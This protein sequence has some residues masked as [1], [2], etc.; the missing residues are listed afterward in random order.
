[1]N[2]R[3]SKFYF[4]R[5]AWYRWEINLQRFLNRNS[6]H[7]SPSIP[8]ADDV[9]LELSLLFTWPV[10]STLL[11]VV[12]NFSGLC[13]KDDSHSSASP[14]FSFICVCLLSQS[15]PTLCD[16][17]DCSPPGSSVCM[18][19]QARILEWV[20]SPPSGDLSN[21]GIKPTSSVSPALQ[22]DSL[23]LS[24]MIQFISSWLTHDLFL[25]SLLLLILI[26]LVY[27]CSVVNCVWL[28]PPHGL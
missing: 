1:M 7:L 19:L 23:P 11:W 14:V 4:I 5:W 6:S 28:L 16:P 12:Y 8:V 10:P 24:K 25:K 18:I 21:P 2:E 9:H 17:T 22:A 13:I 26:L 20:A 3:K 27:V 15:G